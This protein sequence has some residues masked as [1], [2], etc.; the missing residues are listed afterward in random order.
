[1]MEDTP[2]QPKDYTSEYLNSQSETLNSQKTELS[3][4]LG[5]NELLSLRNG[6]FIIYGKGTLVSGVLTVNDN[7]I[8]VPDGT[9]NKGSVALV[10][11]HTSGG[12][13]GS[14]LRAV[15]TAG[16]L[17]IT[18]MRITG[19]SAAGGGA[20][21]YTGTEANTSDTSTVNYLVIL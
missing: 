1:M 11:Y 8:R 2:P 6:G 20:I 13:M 4:P 10:S 17:T 18:S 16:V 5:L 9:K 7:R 15:C 12:T 14:T 21:T 3:F 19:T